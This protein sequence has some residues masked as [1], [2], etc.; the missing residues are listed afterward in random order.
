MGQDTQLQELPV[1]DATNMV[2]AIYLKGGRHASESVAKIVDRK[3]AEKP[4][5]Y[6]GH[7]SSEN[8]ETTAAKIMQIASNGKPVYVLINMKERKDPAEENDTVMERYRTPDGNIVEIDT[9]SVH[10]QGSSKAI[11]MTDFHEI[12]LHNFD[13][14][15]YVAFLKGRTNDAAESFKGSLSMGVIQRKPDVKQ[16][17]TGSNRVVDKNGGAQV[18]YLLGIATPPYVVASVANEDA[19]EQQ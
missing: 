16:R 15:D 3:A 13:L 6:W 14:H 19:D 18:R 2:N 12:D 9:N 11:V 10:V 1:F 4:F 5:T 17:D 8:I 7:N